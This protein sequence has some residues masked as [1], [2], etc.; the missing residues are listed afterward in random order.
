MSPAINSKRPIRAL[1][2]IRQIAKIILAPGVVIGSSFWDNFL[3][4][5]YLL[6]IGSS[7]EADIYRE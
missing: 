6:V 3:T 5:V 1:A 2:R 7:N 4:V